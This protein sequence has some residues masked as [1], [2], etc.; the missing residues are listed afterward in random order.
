MDFNGSASEHHCKY[1]MKLKFFL[2]KPIQNQDQKL[3]DLFLFL[4][5]ISLSNIV[6]SIILNIQC[7]FQYFLAPSVVCCHCKNQLEEIYWGLFS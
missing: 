5:S 7:L 6:C 2:F 3:S 4:F 1:N